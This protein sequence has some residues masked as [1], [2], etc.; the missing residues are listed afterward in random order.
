VDFTKL[1]TSVMTKH[2]RSEE[3]GKLSQTS[4]KSIVLQIAGNR[5]DGD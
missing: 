5:G 4:T 3:G 2:S 1:L